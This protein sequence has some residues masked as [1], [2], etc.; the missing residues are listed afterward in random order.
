M[1]DP[2][3]LDILLPDVEL[4]MA[5]DPVIVREY[6]FVQGMQAQALAKP[7]L[8]DLAAVFLPDDAPDGDDAAQAE[9]ILNALGE[10]FGRHPHLMVKLLAMSTGKPA[11]WIESLNDEDGQTLLLTWWGVNK[12]FFARR[13]TT[14]LVARRGSGLSAGE[15]SLHA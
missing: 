6:R 8:D 5:G 10:I 13:L 1:N 9:G 4:T 12:D 14:Y 15:K 2:D 11:D 3:E 7:L